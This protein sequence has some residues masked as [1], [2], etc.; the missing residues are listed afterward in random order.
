MSR[1]VVEQNFLRERDDR[2]RWLSRFHLAEHV[3]L[4]V[5]RR[6]RFLR[7]ESEDVL[8]ADRNLRVGDL[9][10]PAVV[11][12][13][14]AEVGDRVAGIMF[15]EEQLARVVGQCDALRRDLEVNFRGCR[16]RSTFE[17]QLDGFAHSLRSRQRLRVNAE[18][19]QNVARRA[20]R[21][22]LLR[23]IIS[24]LDVALRE[25]QTTGQRQRCD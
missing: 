15:A 13:V 11:V 25:R 7:H 4:I 18:Q 12:G 8:V 21:H 19:I 23:L 9:N 22:E 14:E 24:V 10:A 5:R 3:A 6:S 2:R 1:G 17:Q 16:Q 20:L